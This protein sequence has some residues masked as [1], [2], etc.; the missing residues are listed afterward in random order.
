M[1]PAQQHVFSC[2]KLNWLSVF[3]YF[4]PKDC[5]LCRH[6]SIVA[7]LLNARARIQHINMDIFIAQT[8]FVFVHR[9]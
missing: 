6:S 5:G 9:V 3:L 7:S 1:F 2:C 4:F 8:P